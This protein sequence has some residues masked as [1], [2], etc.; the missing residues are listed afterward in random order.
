MAFYEPELGFVE[1]VIMRAQ[2]WGWW[3]GHKLEIPEDYLQAF[4]TADKKADALIYLDL[5]AGW[6]T[7]KDAAPASRP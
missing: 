6:P 1:A 2:P 7:N 3:T 5:F 4:T